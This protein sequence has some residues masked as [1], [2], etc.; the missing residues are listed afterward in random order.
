MDDEALRHK[1]YVQPVCLMMN[2]FSFVCFYLLL[3]LLDGPKQ[4]LNDSF[5]IPF[6]NADTMQPVH[7]IL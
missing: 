6:R 1:S 5:V 2:E 4:K 3:I 7:C